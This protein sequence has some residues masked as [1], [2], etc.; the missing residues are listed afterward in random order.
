MARKRFSR[1]G[2]EYL[3]KNFDVVELLLKSSLTKL[4]RIE[5][6]LIGLQNDQKNVIK[7]R[8]ENKSFLKCS[9]KDSDFYN[10]RMS[11]LDRDIQNLKQELAQARQDNH[12][13]GVC[14]KRY[15]YLIYG[16]PKLSDLK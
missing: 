9:S 7:D 6:E 8:K 1:S 13:V 14:F 2:L 10:Q 12:D 15:Y 5:S 4:K 3:D 11:L 16:R